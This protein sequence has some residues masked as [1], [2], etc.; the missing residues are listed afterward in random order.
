MLI[1]SDQGVW[2]LL[3]ASIIHFQLY[4]IV[5]G[6]LWCAYQVKEITT[7]EQK[8]KDTQGGSYNGLELHGIDEVMETQ[9]DE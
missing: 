7:R 1:K 2:G 3:F 8:L 5:F 4:L 9:E 6:M